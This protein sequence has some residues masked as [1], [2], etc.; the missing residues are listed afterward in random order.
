M[1]GLVKNYG[2][3]VLSGVL[4][5]L[6]FPKWGLFPLAWVALVPVV[7]RAQGLSPSRAAIQF[8]V[9]GW[10]FHA[11]VLHWL[12]GNVYWAG[13]WAFVGY[14]VLC[15]ILASYRGVVGLVWVWLRGRAPALGG[16]VSLALLWAAMEV[17]DSY[18]F[19][20]F[21]WGAV[22]YSQGR[23]LALAQWA[24][25]GGAPLVSAVVVLFNALVALAIVEKGGVR[26][27]RAAAAAA[28]LVLGHVVGT[29][30]LDEADYDSRPLAVGLV[31][32]DFPLEMK[33]DAEYGVE[34]VRNAAEKSRLLVEQK[35]VDLFVWPEAVIMHQI[36][37]PGIEREVTALTK[38]TG[39]PLY[40]GSVRYDEDQK[41]W[42]NSSYL[43]ASD[44]TIVD[45]YD[46][47]H[48][49]PFGEYAPFAQHFPFLKA[50]VPAIG[51]VMFGEGPKAWPVGG[52]T[53]GPLICF[54][55]LFARL[56]EELRR[57]G[58]DC[59]VVITNLGWF[60]ASSAIPQEF[61]IARLRAVETRIPVVHCANTGISG[62]FD[63]W[64]RF[65]LIEGIFDQFG[66]LRR[67][68]EGV[69][70][71]ATIMR[72][73]GGVLPVAAP[74]KRPVP[75]GPCVVPWLAVAGSGLL[76]LAGLATAFKKHTP[77]P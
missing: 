22:A 61:E 45:Y 16:A 69:S 28:V 70:P 44:G 46:K 30:L 29:A 51:D 76:V 25:V 1:R 60:G 10:V 38:E 65:T 64:G 59:I 53:I 62:V 74:G 4:L 43:I 5:A 40:V 63:P 33:W 8:F 77:K 67:F 26:W 31:Q 9:A 19:T 15:T 13:G 73:A 3:A 36:E 12:M 54:E 58:A 20:G 52:R 55:V 48:L 24:A 50:M 66:R 21:G 35:P 56:A 32:T 47:V 39:V 68:R 2:W 6:C 7:C 23:D 71:Q 75:H 41:G 49:C 37:T 17:A 57:M 14:L 72:R 34:M 18:L 42:P 11:M 27:L